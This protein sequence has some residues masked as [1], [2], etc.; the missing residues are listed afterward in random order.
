[1]KKLIAVYGVVAGVLGF[2]NRSFAEE[3][4]PADSVQKMAFVD[5]Q[6]SLQSVEAGKRAKA[7]LEKEFNAKKKELQTEEAA[8]KKVT[9]EFKKQSL[10]LSEEARMKKQGEIQERIAKFQETTMRSQQEIQQK[11]SDLTAP[12]VKGIREVIAEIAKKK[13]YTAV[14]ERNENTV[15]YSMERDELTNEV[16][17][18]YNEKDGKKK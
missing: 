15:L 4:G 2:L 6:K 1:M 7:Q 5:M 8:I 16:I 12:L 10:V 17:A 14:F 18:A 13:G 3:K 11:E 9:E